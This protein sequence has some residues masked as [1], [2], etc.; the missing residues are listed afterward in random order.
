MVMFHEFLY[1]HIFQKFSWTYDCIAFL[2]N[3]KSGKVRDRS[4][5]FSRLFDLIISQTPIEINQNKRRL[6]VAYIE[7]LVR[8][9]TTDRSRTNYLATEDVNLLLAARSLVSALESPDTALW[10][11][12]FAVSTS[13]LI[14]TNVLESM[15]V[16][17]IQNKKATSPCSASSCV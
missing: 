17:L 8:S 1:S 2:I 14:Q 3:K 4:Q 10:R 11:V 9:V 15:N 16:A 12:V 13:S 6:E 5:S 7:D